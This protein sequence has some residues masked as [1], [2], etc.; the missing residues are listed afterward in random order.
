MDE[1]LSSEDKK[2]HNFY[3]LLGCDPSSSVEQ[4]QAEYK[5]LALQHHPDKNPD[6]AQ[7]EARFQE[8]QVAKETLT[9]PEK[10]AQYDR[11]LNSG[12][13]VSYEKWCA[14]KGHMTTTLHWAAPNTKDRMLGPAGTSQGPHPHS[15]HHPKPGGRRSSEQG[16]LYGRNQDEVNIS[17]PTGQWERDSSDVIRKFRNYE[18]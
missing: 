4:I 14:M 17:W 11:W 1:I 8:L 15:H 5:V 9:D 16:L 13:A 18:I 3:I 10:R 6:D 7:A 2:K 12:I